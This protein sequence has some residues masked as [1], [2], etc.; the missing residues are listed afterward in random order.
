MIPVFGVA[1][2]EAAKNAIKDGS[3][4]GTIKQDAE[5][6][7]KAITTIT[8]NLLGSKSLFEGVDAD[9]VVDNW[10]VNIPYQIYLGEQRQHP[11]RSGFMPLRKKSIR[12]GR[13]PV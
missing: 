5:G 6:M 13:I 1:A 9:M 11:F 12:K 4:I 7:A 10:R 2:T 8:Q 3:M